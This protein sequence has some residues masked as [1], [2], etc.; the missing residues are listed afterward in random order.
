MS[1]GGLMRCQEAA[2]GAH[3]IE[4]N[5]TEQWESSSNL[6]ASVDILIGNGQNSPI[7]RHAPIRELYF[8]KS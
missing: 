6:F 7:G 4:L 3:S 1:T 2:F 8:Y 5:N